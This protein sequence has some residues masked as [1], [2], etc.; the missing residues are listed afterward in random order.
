LAL[1]PFPF[2]FPSWAVWLFPFPWDSHGN[3]IPMG[4]PTPMHTSAMQL[5]L[6]WKKQ[7]WFHRF[8]GEGQRITHRCSPVL[9]R[10]PLPFSSVQFR[11]FCSPI[12]ISKLSHVPRCTVY[13]V[14]YCSTLQCQY[15]LLARGSTHYISELINICKPHDIYL[16]CVINLASE[17]FLQQ[18]FHIKLQN[19]HNNSTVIKNRKQTVREII[20]TSNTSIKHNK[21]QQN[22]HCFVSTCSVLICTWQ[23]RYLS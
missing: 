12:L 13:T 8:W 5:L 16:Q 15:C 2:P 18:F 20:L 19:A 11:N 1:F 7:V 9:T 21:R 17:H 14:C 10:C 23:L 4:F 6:W 3:G 22:L